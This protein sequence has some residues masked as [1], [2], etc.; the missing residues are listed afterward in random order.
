MKAS[1]LVNEF[2]KS[3]KSARS[4][5]EG[6]AIEED[7]GAS[8][9]SVVSSDFDIPPA[10]H[11][12][13]EDEDEESLIERLEKELTTP[14]AKKEKKAEPPKPAI[15]ES[16]ELEEYVFE[17]EVKSAKKELSLD[18]SDDGFDDVFRMMGGGRGM[19]RSAPL[20]EDI[21]IEVDY[22]PD[23]GEVI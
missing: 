4:F 9:S 23:F 19:A 15:K 18:E 11:K 7:E 12:D 3:N 10:V 20:K 8:P 6:G 2:L 13:D 5:L 17:S 16:E 22:Q 1:N 14:L 21:D